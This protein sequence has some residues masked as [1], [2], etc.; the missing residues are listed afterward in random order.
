VWDSFVSY[1][2]QHIRES[3]IEIDM[4][5]M[6]QTEGSGYILRRLIAS[7][8]DG[9]GKF[10]LTDQEAVSVISLSLSSSPLRVL[11]LYFDPLDGGHVYDDV[12]WSW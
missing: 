7:S 6:E 4:Q 12:R 11:R 3:Q 8:I 10:S 1:T 9:A 5:D 2:K